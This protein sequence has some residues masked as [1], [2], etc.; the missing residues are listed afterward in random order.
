MAV[1][2]DSAPVLRDVSGPSALGGGR[3]RA[4]ELLYVIAVTDFK[5]TYFGTALGYMWSLARPLL[6]FGV[7]L[8]VFTHIVRFT[9]PHYP[10]FLLFNIVLF[11]FFQEATMLAVGSIVGHESIVRKTQF[12]RLVIPLAVVCTTLFNLLPSLVVAFVFL[13]ASGVA[14]EPSWLL[15]SVIMVLLL[16][17]TTAVSMT[18]S[19][20]YPR[21][22]DIGIIWGVLS[23]ALF[24]ATPVLYPMWHVSSTLRDVIALN[25]LAPVF[26]LTQRWITEP[27]APWPGAAAV[28]GPARLAFAAA[29]YATVC[30]LAVWIF[31]R[32]AP[33]IAEAL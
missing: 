32:E 19:A 7:L 21:F 14:P 29:L 8:V 10:E 1:A 33:R 2:E 22:R 6:T 25:P 16:G 24:Y 12:P 9:V 3:R 15:L 20:L 31:R 11:G 18:V 23:L 30:V 27:S 26:E 28:G 4:L 5:R 17:F 13:L